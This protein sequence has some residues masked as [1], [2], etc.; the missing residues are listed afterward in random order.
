M[1]NKEKRITGNITKISGS[2]WGFITSK[3]IEFTRIFFHWSALNQNTLNFKELHLGMRVEFV[4]IQLADKGYRAVRIKVLLPL[5]NK[6][7]SI[8]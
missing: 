2:G 3:E 7:S 1:T 4:P 5:E 6:P 8:D